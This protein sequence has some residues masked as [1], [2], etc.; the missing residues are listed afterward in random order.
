MKALRKRWLVVC[1]TILFTLSSLGCGTLLY[2][3]RLSQQASR[4][5]DVKVVVLDCAWFLLAIWPGFVALG[6]DVVNETIFLPECDLELD[7]EDAAE[8]AVR[9]HG[10]APAECELSLR[11]V[12]EDGNDLVAPTTV[13]ASPEDTTPSVLRIKMPSKTETQ[14]ARLVLA[15]DD[16]PRASWP[17]R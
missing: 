5:L 11:V 17:V 2:P 7:S 6:V 13:K 3:E 8:V 15:V 12:N 1:V 10:A 9:M 14:Q 16:E 4:K